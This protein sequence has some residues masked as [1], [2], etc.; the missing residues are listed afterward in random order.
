LSVEHGHRGLKTLAT[1]VGLTAAFAAGCDDELPTSV[2]DEIPAEPVSVEILIP[3]SGFASNLAVFGG[4]GSPSELGGGVLAN[5]YEGTLTAHTL[6]DFRSYPSVASVRDSTGTIRPDSSLTYVGGRLVAFF[7]TIESTNAGPVTIGLGALQNEWDERTASWSLAVDTINDQQPWPEPGAGPVV[8][9][10]TAVWDPAES[11]SAVF[12][13]DSAMVAV[14]ADT[15]GS[16]TGARV[17][18]VDPGARLTLRNALLRVQ[19]RPSLDPDT[20]VELTPITDRL[21]LVYDPQPP[22][23]ADGVRIGG[24]PAWRTVLDVT[25]PEALTGPPEFCAVVTCPHAVKP[26]EISYAALVLTS[27]A[28]EPA[29]QPSDSILLDVRPVFNRASMPKSPLGTSLTG[30]PQGRAVAAPAFGSSPGVTVEIPFTS[31]ARD[32]LRGEDTSGD[33]VPPTLALLSVFEPFSIAF[34]SFEG[35]GSATEPLLRLVLTIGPP[36]ELP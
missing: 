12:T 4:Y 24:A 13:L 23:P 21:T 19:A 17:E 28:S 33:P 11:D 14:W 20:I 34:A 6:I 31:Y 35:P 16:S 15:T 5:A 1:V 3:W 10:G 30:G 25:I 27:R 26:G 8:G 2:G 29:F 22:P 18:L 36:V 7:D 32:L 9:F